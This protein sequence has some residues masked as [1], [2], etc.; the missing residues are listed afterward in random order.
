MKRKQMAILGDFFASLAG[1][2]LSYALFFKLVPSETVM[3]AVAVVSSLIFFYISR[4]S[5]YLSPLEE[6][7]NVRFADFPYKYL[8]KQILACG[9]VTLFLLFFLFLAYA[10]IP[11]FLR[12]IAPLFV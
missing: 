5:E 2:F 12:L 8:I 4:K 7:E 10:F 1:G 6:N 9:G 11:A 3:I